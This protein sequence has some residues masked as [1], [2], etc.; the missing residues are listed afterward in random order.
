MNT[1]HNMY[2]TLIRGQIFF[3]KTRYI[4]RITK[5]YL[6][7]MDFS[8]QICHE[9][10]QPIVALVFFLNMLSQ[11]PL[12]KCSFKF[13]SLLRVQSRLSSPL[14]QIFAA[15]GTSNISIKLR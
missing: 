5:P 14:E 9:C 11:L 15:L 2:Y 8:L 10:V 4:T 7:K 12:H 6:M 3:D 13:T 1:Q